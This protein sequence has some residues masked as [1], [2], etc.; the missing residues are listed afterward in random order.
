M[1]QTVQLANAEAYVNALARRLEA[2]G[3]RAKGITVVD[4][5]PAEA[6]AA[7]AREQRA[8]LVSIASRHRGRATGSSSAA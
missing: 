7:C 5:N 2:R 6:I 3:Y 8:E 1:P 4:A